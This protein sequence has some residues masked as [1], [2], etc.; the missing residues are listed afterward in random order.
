[1]FV[2]DDTLYPQIVEILQ[3]Q[4]YLSECILYRDTVSIDES[5]I[6]M[7]SE[8]DRMPTQTV[9]EKYDQIRVNRLD[10]LITILVKI[11]PCF[12]YCKFLLFKS[13][14]M[15]YIP[16]VNFVELTLITHPFIKGYPISRNIREHYWCRARG[17]WASLIYTPAAILYNLQWG[18]KNGSRKVWLLLP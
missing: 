1:M 18:E 4:R 9:M 6:I 11:G 12:C 17:D 16:H 3:L 8:L 7:K 2:H 10:D 5:I 14:T 13:N 15:W